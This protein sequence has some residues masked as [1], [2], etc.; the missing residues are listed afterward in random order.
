MIFG[1][2]KKQEESSSASPA[3]SPAE[4]Q[5][6]LHRLLLVVDGADPSIAAAR[7]AIELA[8]FFHSEILAVYVVDTATMDYLMQMR[9]LV[10]EEREA[11]EQDL[12][13]TGQKYLD[14]IATIARKENIEIKTTR[15]KGAYHRKILDHARKEQVDGIVVGGWKRS[16][17]SKDRMS[18]ERQLILDEA[19]CPVIVIKEYPLPTSS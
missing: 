1:F 11:F 18:V 16:I 9:I 12:E 13:R 14:Y 4:T 8:K 2:G 17:T 19:P 5:H 7:F 10:K 6:P 3:S 15:L